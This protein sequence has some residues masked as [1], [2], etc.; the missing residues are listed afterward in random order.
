M[1]GLMQGIKDVQVET[2][3][4]EA[5]F[6]KAFQQNWDETVAKADAVLAKDKANDAVYKKFGEAI[7][8]TAKL[9]QV[10]NKLPGD[11]QF[12]ESGLIRV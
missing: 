9:Q 12:D 3:K 8:K 4:N 5:K 11:A 7:V 1:L 2:A 10:V 6:T